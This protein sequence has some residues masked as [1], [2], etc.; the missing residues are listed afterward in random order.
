MLVAR[1][2]GM[3]AVRIGQPRVMGEVLAGIALGPT[4]FG[5]IAP[6]AQRACSRPTSSPTSASRPTWG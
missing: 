1:L 3:L 4:L 5:A 6:E 2:V